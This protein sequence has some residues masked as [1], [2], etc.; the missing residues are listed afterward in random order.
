MALSNT[1][2]RDYVFGQVDD[3]DRLVIQHRISKP[4]FM[5]LME[6]VLD[7]YGL[8]AKFKSGQRVKLL[9]AG[10]SEGLFLHDIAE[11][12]EKRGWLEQADFYGI[13]KDEAAIL[14]ASAYSHASRPP[15]P[16]LNFYKHDLTRPLINCEGL[17]LDGRPDFDLI[18]LLAVLEHIPDA[19]SCLAN[20]YNYIAPGGVIYVRDLVLHEGED[21][22]LS[23]HPASDPIGRA[24]LNYILAINKGVD[25]SIESQNW[26]QELAAE[27]IETFADKQISGG[28]S[29][30]GMDLLRNAVMAVRNAG[31]L[32]IARGFLTQVQFNAIMEQMFR[33]IGPNTHGQ[34][35]FMDTLA[36]KP[37]V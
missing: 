6:R 25:V 12:L 18:M 29:Q 35:V 10:C 16:Y 33:D 5:A 15:R 32:L 7:D 26:L 3:R 17:F 11:L 37:L 13:D 21:G 31:P 8:A 34:I 20:I 27:Q 22:W 14:T 30:A 36:R 19:K 2:Y 9:D 4:N 28:N 1:E 23:A 24:L